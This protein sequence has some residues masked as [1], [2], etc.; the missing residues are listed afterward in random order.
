MARWLLAEIT[1]RAAVADFPVTTNPCGEIAL[2]VTGGYCVIA[3]FAPLLACPVP[4]DEVLPGAPE[5]D[6]AALWDARVEDSVRLGIRFLMRANTHGQPLRRGGRCAPTAWA[7]AP[8]ACTN[9]PGCASAW[10]STT[11]STRRAS[12]PF[13]AML[14]RLSGGGEGRGRRSIPRN[15]A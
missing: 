5:P 15:S 4:F 10:A 12:A 9:G 7:S 1:R 2:H 3:D 11:C 14:E 6:V 13:W 8:P